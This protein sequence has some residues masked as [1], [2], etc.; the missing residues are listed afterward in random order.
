MFEQ[1]KPQY[2]REMLAI[3]DIPTD[4]LVRELLRRAEEEPKRRWYVWSNE[5]ANDSFIV[6]GHN[7]F[8]A[9]LSALS[10]LN[11]SIAENPI[12]EENE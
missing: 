11:M 6:D 12:E 3:E 9:A 2:L 10:E 8:D 4:Y 1:K 5:D 7:A